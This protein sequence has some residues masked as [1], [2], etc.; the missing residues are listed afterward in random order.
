MCFAKLPY[1]GRKNQK[2]ATSKLETML[3]NEPEDHNDNNIGI[4]KSL[5]NKIKEDLNSLNKEDLANFA[6]LKNCIE[7]KSI[8]S[9]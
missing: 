1:E 4:N 7:I 8:I 9:S 5:R 6:G 3:M 2:I